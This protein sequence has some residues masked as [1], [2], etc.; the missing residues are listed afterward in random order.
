MN[1]HFL[2]VPDKNGRPPVSRLLKPVVDRSVF[3]EFLNA[4]S[5][6]DY[7]VLISVTHFISRGL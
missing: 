7:V 5:L 2:M 6:I 1:S 4:K 3:L